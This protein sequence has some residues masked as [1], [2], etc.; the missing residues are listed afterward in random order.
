MAT[1]DL[2]KE[3]DTMTTKLIMI[4]QDLN[5]E[6]D[7][8]RRHQLLNALETALRE[9]RITLEQYLKEGNN[10]DSHA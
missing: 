6:I 5:R 3:E 2:N 10:E 7:L 1:E 9:E 8:N 4:A